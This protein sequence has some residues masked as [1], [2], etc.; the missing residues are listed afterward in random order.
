MSDWPDG[1]IMAGGRSVSIQWNITYRRLTAWIDWALI[2]WTAD[3]LSREAVRE[4]TTTKPRS[5]PNVDLDNCGLWWWWRWRAGRGSGCQLSGRGQRID[6][7]TD[8]L[9]LW[10]IKRL[11]AGGVGGGGGGLIDKELETGGGR[12]FSWLETTY[13]T[14]IPV[15]NNVLSWGTLSCQWGRYSFD[16][17]VLTH[18]QSRDMNRI[19]WRLERGE[20]LPGFV[21]VNQLKSPEEDRCNA[22][23]ADNKQMLSD[24][25]SLLF[26]IADHKRAGGIT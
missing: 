1:R 2:D 24:A 3:S 14:N 11:A 26:E 23:V 7:G 16:G 5:F 15:V 25:L 6:V 20:I 12:E 18:R 22:A 9:P 4:L 8:T 13:R 21:M 17:F 10:Q 19:A